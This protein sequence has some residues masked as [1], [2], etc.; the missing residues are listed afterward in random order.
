MGAPVMVNGELVGKVTKFT[1]SSTIGKNIGY[2]LVERA[3][4]KVGDRVTINGVEAVLTDR[5]IVK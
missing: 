1:Y 3:K 5:Q 4:A 2:A